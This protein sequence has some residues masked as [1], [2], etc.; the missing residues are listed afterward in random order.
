[1]GIAANHYVVITLFQNGQ[2][3]GN[4]SQ[5]RSDARLKFTLYTLSRLTFL[6][7]HDNQMHVLLF[8]IVRLF[9]EAGSTEIMRQH[10]R[11]YS[12]STTI[13]FPAFSMSLKPWLSQSKSKCE[14]GDGMVVRDETKEGKQTLPFSFYSSNHGF[15]WPLLPYHTNFLLLLLIIVTINS[16]KVKKEPESICISYIQ[17]LTNCNT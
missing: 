2:T 6:C 3:E 9:T 10:D 12:H 11:K 13:E 1:M 17:D 8:C 5:C 16:S 14:T 7:L 4:T 15:Q